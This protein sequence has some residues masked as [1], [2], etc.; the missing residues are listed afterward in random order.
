MNTFVSSSNIS[1]RKLRCENY[2]AIS[3]ATVPLFWKL[4]Q[5]ETRANNVHARRYPELCEGA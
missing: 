4:Q 3:A 1:E 5:R 2:G